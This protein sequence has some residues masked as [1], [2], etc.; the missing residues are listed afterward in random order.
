MLKIKTFIHT[1]TQDRKTVIDAHFAR[2]MR[3]LSHFMKTW[4]QNKITRINTANGIGFALAW[5]KGMKNVMVQVVN[6]D[7]TR[8]NDI[9]N[10]F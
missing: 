10:I 2:Y 5:N 8:M 1:E 7:R 6:T 4:K 3:F 9:L